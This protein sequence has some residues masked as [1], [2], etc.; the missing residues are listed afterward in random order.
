[1]SEQKSEFRKQMEEIRAKQK[2]QSIALSQRELDEQTAKAK[3]AQEAPALVQAFFDD[4][5]KTL[6]TDTADIP[7]IVPAQH[8]VGTYE[9]EINGKRLLALQALPNE[10]EILLSIYSLPMDVEATLRIGE[11]TNSYAFCEL[12]WNKTEWAWK[13][14]SR[15]INQAAP[16]MTHFGINQRENYLRG[17]MLSAQLKQVV[18]DTVLKLMNY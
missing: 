12:Y 10:Y 2:Q 14:N 17:G 7:G 15:W 6:D 13:F 3:Q 16:I 9:L 18:L 4:V 11:G 5:I 1:M 8:F